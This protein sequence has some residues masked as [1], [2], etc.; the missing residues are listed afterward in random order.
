MDPV[1]QTRI[2]RRKEQRRHKLL[3]FLAGEAI[4]V[5][6]L[7]LALGLSWASGSGSHAASLWT[8]IPTILAAIAV[9]LI[10]VIFYGPSATD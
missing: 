1:D 6:A 10:P 5:L 7:V 2:D 9:V 8:R 3:R 4:A